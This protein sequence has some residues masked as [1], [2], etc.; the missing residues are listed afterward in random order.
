MQKKSRLF[1]IAFCILILGITACGDIIQTNRD[2]GS[3]R[4]GRSYGN[5]DFKIRVKPKDK[6]E[7][8]IIDVVNFHI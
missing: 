7:V 5:T 4:I 8:E 3:I 6:N 1:S 2:Y